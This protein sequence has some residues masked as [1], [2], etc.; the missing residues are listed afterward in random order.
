MMFKRILDTLGPNNT[1][2]AKHQEQHKVDC[3]PETRKSLLRDI[4]QWLSPPAL[5]NHSTSER[6]WW[7][8]GPPAMG[9]SAVAITVAKRL[10]P[11]QRDIPKSSVDGPLLVL[12]AQ[13][14]VN[15]NL[16][17]SNPHNI[18]PT[19]AAQLAKLDHYA[20]V[21]LHD[22]IAPMIEHRTTYPLL[23]LSDYQADLLFVRPLKAICESMECKNRVLVIV[24]DGIDELRV[25]KDLDVDPV[26]DFTKILCTVSAKLPQNVRVLVLS[27]PEHSICKHLRSPS[28]SIRTSSFPMAELKEDVDTFLRTNI[29]KMVESV[30][31]CQDRADWPSEDQIDIIRITAQG[32]VAIAKA[33]ILLI[34]T[35]YRYQGMPRANKMF[36]MIKQVKAGNLYHFYEKLL[37][38][39]VLETTP[40]LDQEGCTFVLACIS[41]LQ[42]GT[43]GIISALFKAKYPKNDDF[44]TSHFFS[45]IR[46]IV[47][48]NINPIDN[49]TIPSPHKSLVDYLTSEETPEPFRVA[50]GHWRNELAELCFTIMQQSLHFN[51]GEITTS[52]SRLSFDEFKQTE[53][54]SKKP[55]LFKYTADQPISVDL[56]VAYACDTFHVHLGQATLGDKRTLEMVNILVKELLLFW[57]EVISLARYHGMIM[58][59]TEPL[60]FEVTEFHPMLHAL[61]LLVKV[62]SIYFYFRVLTLL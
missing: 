38:D 24:L 57:M 12:G 34:Q 39:V 31:H 10:E 62:S 47:I 32:H 29:R 58:G 51:M 48:Q 56:S 16:D 4:D 7:I 44:D 11:R 33:A 55:R 15:H 25:N 13:Y 27:R 54:L 17:S 53:I 19:I 21:S 22:E 14:F 60:V 49:Q 3:H 26:H 40:P 41:I 5:H 46:S 9:K 2:K 59:E 50:V 6:L 42:N 35:T 37:R 23:E 36:E 20:R 43:I 1:E 8:T 45:S 52:H 61:S 28:T 30:D 18:F